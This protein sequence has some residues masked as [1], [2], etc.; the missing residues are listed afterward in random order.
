M[1]DRKMLVAELIAFSC[2]IT[3]CAKK[4]SDTATDTVTASA[5]AAVA[6]DH[7]ADAHTII[8]SDSAWMRNVIAK[9]VDSLMTYYAPEAVSYGF[10]APASGTDQIRTEYTNMVKSTITI[11]KIDAGPVSFSNDGS[12]AFDHGI[13]SM[14][15]T[16]PGGKASN[17]TG[18]YL[19]V[20]KKMNGQWKLVAEMSTPV[21]ASK[22]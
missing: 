5:P 21:P 9:N 1:Q 2:I 19:N 11:P 16:P 8:A 3:G 18:A 12:M 22:N 17:S 4:A 10:G 15:V 13:Y 14:T 6:T 20:W 7:S